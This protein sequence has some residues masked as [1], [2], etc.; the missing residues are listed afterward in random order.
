VCGVYFERRLRS[1]AINPV[2]LADRGD[3]EIVL[4]KFFAYWIKAKRYGENEK[5]VFITTK[6][7]DEARR[8][9]LLHGKEWS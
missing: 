3:L 8:E 5:A 4:D 7:I 6:E 9:L 1:L 2:G